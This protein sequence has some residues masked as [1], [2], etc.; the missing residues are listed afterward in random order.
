MTWKAAED[1]RKGSLPPTADAYK[2]ELPGDF[3]PP[4][5]VE[6]KLDTT[7]PS[8][9]QLKAVAH[10]HGLTQ[11]A[12]NELI[13][14]YA[15]NEVG[16]QAR[17]TAAA[18][19]EVT[20][21]GASGPARVDAVTRFLDASGMGVLKSTLVTAAQVEAWESHITRL[22][23]QGSASFSQSGRVAP[24]DKAIPGFKDMSFEQR[25]FAQDQLRARRSG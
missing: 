19:A 20:K 15:G 24:D 9:G 5:G 7:N 22:T 17:I 8:M 3:K 11:D 1:V 2:L 12:V 14:V 21:L 13:G 16:T 6:F 10:K 4:A 23:S 25:R 18:S